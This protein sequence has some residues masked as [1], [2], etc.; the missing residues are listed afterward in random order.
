[1]QFSAFLL[2][3]SSLKKEQNKQVATPKRVAGNIYE[4]NKKIKARWHLKS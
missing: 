1:M 3:V 2:F 4:S